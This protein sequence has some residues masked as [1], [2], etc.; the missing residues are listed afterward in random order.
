MS[1]AEHNLQHTVESAD[2][3]ERL[4]HDAA[5]WG[6]CTSNVYAVINE[7]GVNVGQGKIRRVGPNAW[8]YVDAIDGC[9]WHDDQS[10]EFLRLVPIEDHRPAGWDQNGNVV[11]CEDDGALVG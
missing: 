3:T 1:N 8:L 4:T 10:A 6:A 5:I 7:E 9:S 2:D 11:D